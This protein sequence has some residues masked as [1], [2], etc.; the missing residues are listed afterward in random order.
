[1]IRR[2]AKALCG[3]ALSFVIQWRLPRLLETAPIGGNRSHGSEVFLQFGI[4]KKGFPS[5]SVLLSR[6]YG[7]RA[8]G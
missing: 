7:A 6:A 4:L 5:R 8:V 1:M 3:Q 2:N